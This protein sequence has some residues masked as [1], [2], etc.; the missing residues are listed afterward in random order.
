MDK[1]ALLGGSPAKTK[2]F[3]AWPHYD[4][5]ERE[6]LMQVLDSRTWW[7]TPGTQTLAS[8]ASSPR[9]K[10]RG[11]AS[12]LPMGPPPS[13]SRSP[14]WALAWATRDRADFTFV[15]TAMRCVRRG[16]AGVG[17]CHAGYLLHRSDLV[18]AAITERTQAIIAVHVGGHP[19]DLDRLAAI[20]ERHN[21]FLV[22]DSCTP[23]AANG[24]PQGRRAG[25]RRDVQLPAEQADDGG[26]GRHHRHEQRRHRAPGALG[27]DCGRLPGEWF[28]AHFNYG[29]NYCLSEWQGAVLRQQ[30]PAC[31]NRASAGCATP[32]RSIGRWRHRGHHAPGD[33]PALHA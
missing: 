2:P 5:G 6:A 15:A 20:A 28:Y 14:R 25:P 19:A 4:D 7:R 11:T 30:L 1:L 22:E 12:P 24:R 3:P 16:A 31:R 33:G 10:R 29:S 27:P 18:E 13:R 23:T 21:L 9:F 32:A 17:G 8:S 26:R